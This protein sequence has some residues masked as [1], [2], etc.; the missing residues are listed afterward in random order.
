LRALTLPAGFDT[1]GTAG[2]ETAG[3]G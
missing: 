2:T 1:A 3:T